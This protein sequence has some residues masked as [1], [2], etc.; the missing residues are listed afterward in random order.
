MHAVF[1]SRFCTAPQSTI[2]AMMSSEPIYPSNQQDEQQPLGQQHHHAAAAPRQQLS[3]RSGLLNSVVNAAASVNKALMENCS[4][5]TVYCDQ[6]VKYEDW[7]H[8]QYHISTASMSHLF[9]QVN[10]NSNTHGSG[11]N[12]NG[13]GENPMT[14]NDAQI[15]KYKEFLFDE[16]SVIESVASRDV[17]DD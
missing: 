10:P 14:P 6:Q 2:T 1:L 3:E 11:S 15:N 12:N 17:G 4:L 16:A 5:C 13:G 7:V 9:Q 8:H